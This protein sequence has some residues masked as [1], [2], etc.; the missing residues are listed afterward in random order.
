M[1]RIELLLLLTFILVKT[2]FTQ[3]DFKE[4]IED[5]NNVCFCDVGLV[6]PYTILKMDNNKEIVLALKKGKTLSELKNM[7]IQFNASQ[8]K[9][10][11]LSGLVTKKDSTYTTAIPIFTKSEM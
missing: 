11:T 7:G 2:G 5:Y 3:L 4:N 6:H 8:I 1:K 9:L 10:L